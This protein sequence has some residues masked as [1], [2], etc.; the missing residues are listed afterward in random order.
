MLKTITDEVLGK[1]T[2]FKNL[3]DHYKYIVS[4]YNTGC[5]GKLFLLIHN[6]DGHM[7]RSPNTQAALAHLATSCNIH[8]VASI[9]HINAP[10]VWDQNRTSAFNWLWYDTTTFEAYSEET[11][12]ENSLMV[13]QTGTLALS[14][15][16]HVLHS[17][18]SNSKG[19][20]KVLSD[21]H[22]D[23][24]E[25]ASYQGMAFGDLYQRCRERFLVNS[26]LTLRGQLTEFRDHKLVKSKK[27]VDGVEY[28]S[29]A[30][31][32]ATLR[33]FLEEDG[34]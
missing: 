22:L 26:D 14:S 6:I 8:L 7:L 9:D 13:H 25:N 5:N 32:C 29:I 3:I 28:L 31:D 33:T 34:S 24:E 17:L 10:L 27:G 15:L 16:K 19:I 18:T 23:N 2:L 20:F 12:Y 1:E 30:L 21:Y 11:S 4:E